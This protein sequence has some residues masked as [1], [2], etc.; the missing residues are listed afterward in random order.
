[1]GYSPWGRKD[2]DTAERLSMS[3]NWKEILKIG[4]LRTDLI[5]TL[6]YLSK[7]HLN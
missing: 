5:I 3:T 7:H 4:V 2:A 6:V 1:M